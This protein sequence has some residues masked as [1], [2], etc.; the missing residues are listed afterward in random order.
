MVSTRNRIVSTR[1]RIVSSVKKITERDRMVPFACFAT[2]LPESE[3]AFSV[4]ICTVF[5]NHTFENIKNLLS[6]VIPF[7]RSIEHI[8]LTH[9]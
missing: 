7:R 4:S 6:T 5:S 2:D 3:R 8:T 1:N 9:I